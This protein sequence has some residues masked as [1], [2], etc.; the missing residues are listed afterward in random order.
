MP[1]AKKWQNMPV[2]YS[3]PEHILSVLMTEICLGA[4]SGDEIAC[5]VCFLYLRCKISLHVRTLFR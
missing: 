2:Q 3:F 5:Q 1:C 4:I